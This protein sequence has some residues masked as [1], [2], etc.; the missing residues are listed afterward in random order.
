MTK[1]EIL[2]AF[3]PSSDRMAIVGRNYTLCFT[4]NS[5]GSNGT[6]YWM[7]DGLRVN[8]TDLT[9]PPDVNNFNFV[10]LDCTKC[11]C[12]RTKY[13]GYLKSGVLSWDSRGYSAAT[14]SLH[15]FTEGD[16]QLKRKLCY[17]EDTTLALL[18][19]ESVPATGDGVMLVDFFITDVDG[20][21]GTGML[22]VKTGKASSVQWD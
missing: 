4:I 9:T 15:T 17:Y 11:S 13:K 16:V 6:A 8:A 1:P 22:Q 21:Q 3:V 20:R 7:V 2:L 19:V 12:I 10:A 14:F 18:G 5:K